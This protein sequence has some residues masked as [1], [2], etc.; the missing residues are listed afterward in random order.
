M[1]KYQEWLRERSVD[2]RGDKNFGRFTEIKVDLFTEIKV[3]LFTEI[4]VDLRRYR[5]F[6]RFSENSSI[7]KNINGL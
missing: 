7:S 6:G 2:L 5:G 1:K 4:K 3:D